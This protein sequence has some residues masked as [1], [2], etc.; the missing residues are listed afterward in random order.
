MTTRADRSLA[1]HEIASVVEEI[2][3]ANTVAAKI[4]ILDDYLLGK[5]AMKAHANGYIGIEASAELT[6]KFAKITRRLD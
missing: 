5:A 6:N 3:Q 4:E 2:G 1:N